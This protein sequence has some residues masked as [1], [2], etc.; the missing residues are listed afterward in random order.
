MENF[1]IF[2]NN[3]RGIKSKEDSFMEIIES[4]EPQIIGLVETHLDKNEVINTEKHIFVHNS[5]KKGK[6]GGSHRN[7]KRYVSPNKRTKKNN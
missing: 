3:I 7:K 1:K 4:I 6:G 5:N 2:Y